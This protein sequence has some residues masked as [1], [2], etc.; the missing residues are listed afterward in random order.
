MQQK[1]TNGLTVTINYEGRKPQALSVIH[2]GRV[3]VSAVF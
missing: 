3:Q 2:I 1:L